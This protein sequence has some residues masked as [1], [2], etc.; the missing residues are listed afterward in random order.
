MNWTR[1][2]SI[3]KIEMI[4]AVWGPT[5]SAADI[6]EAISERVGRKVTR[7][8][9]SGAYSRYRTELISHPLSGNS[10]RIGGNRA[11]LP[12]RLKTDPSQR[13]NTRPVAQLWMRAQKKKRRA[14]EEPAIPI[15]PYTSKVD[16]QDERFLPKAKGIFDLASRDCR[17][18]LGEKPHLFCGEPVSKGSYC[19]FHYDIAYTKPQKN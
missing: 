5:L 16:T 11:S 7:N 13:I 9:I 6:A 17:F 2:D 1:L 18:P 10:G 15:E 12:A 14:S 4:K 19:A 8:A 3:E